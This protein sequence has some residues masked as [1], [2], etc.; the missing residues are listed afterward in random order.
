MPDVGGRNGVNFAIDETR[1]KHGEKQNDLSWFGRRYF[2]PPAFNLLCPCSIC[3][4]SVA[5]ISAVSLNAAWRSNHAFSPILRHSNTPFRAPS[6]GLVKPCK[7]SNKK[8]SI[9]CL[10]QI[11][12]KRSQGE[13]SH[14]LRRVKACPT[15]YSITP[16]PRTAVSLRVGWRSNHCAFSPILRHSK[17]PFRAPSQGL[18]KPCQNR[19]NQLCINALHHFLPKISQG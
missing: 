14:Y 19:N 8:L 17:T 2:F 6:Q 4:S 15:H 3:V 11:Q 13:S 7:T 16:C 18:V 12:P 10:L 9:N 5:Q 1:T